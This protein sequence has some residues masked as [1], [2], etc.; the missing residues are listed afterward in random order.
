M[1][2]PT[3]QQEMKALSWPSLDV[4]LVCGDTYIDSPYSGLAMIGKV[5]LNA[6]YR[7]GVIAQPDIN[8]GEDISRLGE[9]KL[10][11]G[12][13]SGT[14]D[15]MVAN[16]TATLRKRR[17][18]DFTPGG[19][20]DRR[21]DRAV[22]I[23]SNLIRR[24][25]KQTAPIILGGIEAS[26]R[27]I[28]HYDY[29]SDR[30]RAPILFDAKADYLL[31]G[32][33]ERSIVQ[34]AASLRDGIDPTNIQGLCY[35][36]HNIPDGFIEV[37]SFEEVS[38]NPQ[39]FSDMFHTF[40][41]NNDANTAKGLAQ[42]KTDRYTIQNPPQSPLTQPEMDQI[43]ALQF[44]RRQHPYYEAQGPAKALET[45]RFS[46]PTH[47]G[48]YGE[49]NF[50][51]IAVHEG[52]TVSSR[53]ESSIVNEAIQIT[54]DPAFK[55]NIYD[56][57]GPTA[58]M[59]AIECSKKLSAGACL[60]KRCLFPDIC[61]ILK[62]DHS[63]QISML[64]KVRQLPGVKKV[65]VGSGI[66]YDMVLADK[67]HG[68]E[69]LKE[70]VEHHTS[71][72]LK[73]APEHADPTVLRMMGKPPVKSL[74]EFK[75]NFDRLTRQAGKD[76][77]LTYYLIAAYPGCGD[78]EMKNLK[79]FALRELHLLPEQVQVFT[80]TPSTYASI[81]YYTEKDPFTGAPIFVEKSL[82]RKEDQ[83]E[84]VMVKPQIG[85]RFSQNHQKT[86]SQKKAKRT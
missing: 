18:D 17:S 23:Y 40:Y 52:R 55:G 39:T 63:R 79:E 37:P 59:Y 20:N 85:S 76:Q 77:Y 14:V 67:T 35:L 19:V 2:L 62:I 75:A 46:I 4:I 29:W 21:P 28:T 56:L 51:A 58:N 83:K 12:V 47:R 60:E 3:T 84:I 11:W 78:R 41:Q 26:L 32:M 1:F 54:H 30:L 86:F 69:Y 73:I 65:F 34:L 10:F 15:S 70:I 7:V 33:A 45:I 44:E 74:V 50:C 5:L 25:F 81:M 57:G 36:S 72:Q 6:G 24:Y 27:R 38:A 64:Q 42:K 82:K 8:S 48:C 68:L 31:Y 16:Y 71:G 49:C 22:I 13:T 43:Y 80:P 53:S 9:P 66:R 61:P